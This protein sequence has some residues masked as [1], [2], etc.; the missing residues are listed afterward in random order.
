MKLGMVA[1]INIV[2]MENLSTAGCR[3]RRPAKIRFRRFHVFYAFQI[4]WNRFAKFFFF[5]VEMAKKY[6]QIFSN[7]WYTH[8]HETFCL[9]LIQAT[10]ID[11]IWWN[12]VWYLVL[13]LSTWKI[14][15]PSAAGTGDR[16]KF[17]FAGFMF[18]TRFRPFGIDLQKIFFFSV[19]M[20]KKLNQIIG[21]FWYAL[22]Y[23]WNE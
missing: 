16:Q 23:F 12:S 10:L 6:Y 20:A 15:R 21:N 9:F 17:G 8:F 13:T 22:L 2:Y 14:C 1:C 5:S 4:I 18:F 7:F 19:E 11:R 3:H